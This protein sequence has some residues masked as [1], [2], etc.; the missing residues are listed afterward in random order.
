MSLPALPFDSPVGRLGNTLYSP[1]TGATRFEQLP[2]SKKTNDSLRQCKYVEMTDSLFSW[3]GSESSLSPNR[4]SV[5][6]GGLLLRR[7]T[8]VHELGFF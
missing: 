4:R 2:V 7:T 1:Y 3:S 5:P 6:I 8:D